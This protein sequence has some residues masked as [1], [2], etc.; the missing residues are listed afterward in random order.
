MNDLKMDLFSFTPK[1]I[2]W[3]RKRIQG[4]TVKIENGNQGF[5]LFQILFTIGVT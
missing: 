5:F 2:D 4:L 3:K 1:N